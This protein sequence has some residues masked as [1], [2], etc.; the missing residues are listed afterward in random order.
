MDSRSDPMYVTLA[1]KLFDK[2]DAVDALREGILNLRAG[3]KFH[4]FASNL[5]FGLEKAWHIFETNMM[6]VTDHTSQLFEFYEAVYKP[7]S[8]STVS[9]LH[10]LHLWM[11]NLLSQWLLIA[12]NNG[13]VEEIIPNFEETLE[14]FKLAYTIY[15]QYHNLGK[16]ISAG[17][18]I[19]HL[20]WN[21]TLS[22]IYPHFCDAKISSNLARL[23]RIELMTIEL[24]SLLSND[25]INKSE[26]TTRITELTVEFHYF[27]RGKKN[28]SDRHTFSYIRREC[29]EVL[30]YIKNLSTDI[31][32]DFQQYI[33]NIKSIVK[34]QEY[35]TELDRMKRY[36]VYL[37]R[38]L[39]GYVQHGNISLQHFF[40]AYLNGE[41]EDVVKMI[42]YD[43]DNVVHSIQEDLV[44]SSYI[45]IQNMLRY[46]STNGED[47][48]FLR[49]IME[50]L[51]SANSFAKSSF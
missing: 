44:I 40:D 6:I 22:G 43:A 45:T 36:S 42:L 15:Q 12:A 51:Y 8:D 14:E 13:N 7:L 4:Q 28:G 35:N 47:L 49:L 48:R 1:K 20:P 18:E 11:A 17:I 5:N 34:P 19:F 41:N 31:R 25:K 9:R 10:N 24:Y 39:E 29:I 27:Y 26:V 46:I 33:L 50:E 37:H 3:E 23:G 2:I 32:K 16:N 38:L 30:G 21:S